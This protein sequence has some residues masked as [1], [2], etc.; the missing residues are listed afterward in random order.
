MP[1]PAGSGGLVWPPP[2]TGLTLAY[3][4][5][6]SRVRIS[7]SSLPPAVSL[8]RVERSTNQA[9]WVTV[10]GAIAL[11]PS[12]GRV[13]VDDYEFR[14]DVANYYRVR[15]YMS[16]GREVSGALNTNPWLETDASGWTGASATVARSTV[17]AHEGVASLLITPDGV[18]ASGGANA[19]RV[20]ATAAADYLASMWVYATATTTVGPAVNWWTALSGGTLVSTGFVG[21]TAVTAGT[22][23]SMSGVLTA[24][25]TTAG[26]GMRA[27]HSGTPTTSQTWWADEIQLN[28]VGTGPIL[29]GTITPPLTNVWLKSIAR[30][31]LNRAVQ[32][33]TY[34]EIAR[35]S[36]AGV[37]DVVG[38]TM[39]VA[40]A[41]VRGSRRWTLN[42]VTDTDQQATDLDL[43]LASGDALFIHV[44]T[45]GLESTTP[46]GYVSVGNTGQRRMGPHLP[47]QVFELPCTEV[48]APGPDVV[49]ATITWQG[50]VATYPTW[51]G[52]VA[53]HATWANV[54]E[55]IGNGTEVVVL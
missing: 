16:D 49:G 51:S 26:A 19:D 2:T 53:A 25:A 45:T 40:V 32:V 7:A 20:T 29:S 30:P 1:V 9:S 37:F 34:S 15:A 23:T 12:V 41:D 38:R 22:W 4:G 21:P 42:L 3:D 18:G 17:R 10:R 50:V 14:P 39:P 28:L 43:I 52:V 35:P 47:Q 13:L 46:S 44:P 54:L 6:L 48:A 24:P 36:R 31:F 33:A 55:L 5:V 8:V 27:R 11:V